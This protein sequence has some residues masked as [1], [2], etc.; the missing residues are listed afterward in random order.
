MHFH[1][2]F[3]DTMNKYWNIKVLNCL[4]GAYPHGK[5]RHLRQ[6]YTLDD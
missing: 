6:E 5:R 3:S 1:M 4:D 2:H